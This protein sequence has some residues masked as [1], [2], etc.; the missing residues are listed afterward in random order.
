MCLS[1]EGTRMFVKRDVI[2]VKRYKAAMSVGQVYRG[3]R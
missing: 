1:E 3:C 2:A